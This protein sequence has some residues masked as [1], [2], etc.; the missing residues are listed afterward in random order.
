M[1]MYTGL[2]GKILLKNNKLSSVIIQKD[3]R[4]EEVAGTICDETISKWADVGRC[5]F[6][7][8]GSVCYMPA[9]W[10]EGWS[11]EGNVLTFTCSLKDYCG[12]IK[13][14]VN[15]VLPHIADAWNLEEFYEESTYSLLFSSQADKEEFN[16]YKQWDEYTGAAVEQRP[17]I[18][19]FELNLTKR[20]TITNGHLP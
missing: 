4:W 5:N 14:F 16:V 17:F 1:G 15:K 9:S 6:I 12:E 10:G 7:P 3:F 20:L 13:A 19:V 8:N 11:V 18:D 2:R